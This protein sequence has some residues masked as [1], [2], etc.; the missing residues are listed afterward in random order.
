MSDVYHYV[1]DVKDMIQVLNNISIF[2]NP[3]DGQLHIQYTTV[4][5]DP[6]NIKLINMLGG[7]AYDRDFQLS[8]N[9][10]IID[11]NKLSEGV[12][13]VCIRADGQIYSQ[14]LIIKH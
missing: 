3:A 11:L 9:N 6:V 13:V 8:D 1:S 14:R 2:P 7:V 12:Y 4:T 5:A 10:L